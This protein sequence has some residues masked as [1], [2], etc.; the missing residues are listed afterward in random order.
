MNKDQKQGIKEEIKGWTDTALGTVTGNE[1]RKVKGDVEVTSGANRKEYGDQKDNIDEGMED[2]GDST[3]EWRRQPQKWARPEGPGRLDPHYGCRRNG[4][5]RYIGARSGSEE[6]R[7]FRVQAEPGR[8]RTGAMHVMRMVA[9]MP[10]VDS[11]RQLIGILALGNI[12]TW[13]DGEVLLT[14]RALSTPSVPS[15]G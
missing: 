9:R 5:R 4:R 13:S 11:E 10:V 6:G 1:N 8:G 7:P 3:I 2:P 15:W 14:P 12:A